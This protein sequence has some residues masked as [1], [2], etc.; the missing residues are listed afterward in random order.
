MARTSFPRCLAAVFASCRALALF[1]AFAVWFGLALPA[2]ELTETLGAD[3]PGL[4]EVLARGETESEEY[5]IGIGDILSVNVWKEPDVSIEQ[6]GVRSDGKISVPLVKE[7]FA[8]GLT[9][10][11]LEDVLTQKLRQYINNPVVTVIVLEV[12]SQRVFIVGNVGASGM[13]PLE[14]GLT[15]MRAIALA[16]GPTEFARRKKIY[17]LREVGGKPQKIPFDYAGVLSGETPEA[18]IELKPGDTIF[19]P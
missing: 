18:D 14:P 11:Q 2:Q 1:G 13:L 4:D 16:G 7:V 15:A 3:V 9:P 17:V 12:R 8:S 6:V 19:V 5:V 10:M